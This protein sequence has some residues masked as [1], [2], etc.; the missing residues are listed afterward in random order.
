MGVGG[1]S[2]VGHR[3]VCVGGCGCMGVCVWMLARGGR[4]SLLRNIDPWKI[5]RFAATRAPAAETIQPGKGERRE[6]ERERQRERHTNTHT[7]THR[8]RERERER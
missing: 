8:E 3:R 5:D 7:H 2:W 6:R 1:E 4:A